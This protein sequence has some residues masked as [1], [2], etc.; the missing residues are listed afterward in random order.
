MNEMMVRLVSCRVRE[1]RQA[2]IDA[3]NKKRSKNNSIR[4]ARESTYDSALRAAPSSASSL[5][6]LY[7]LLCEQV[8]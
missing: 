2:V 1:C 6:Y 5:G 4:E 8:M 7:Y 3:T